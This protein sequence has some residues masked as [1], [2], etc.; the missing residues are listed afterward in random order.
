MKQYIVNVILASVC[1]GV[2]ENVAPRALKPYSKLI[3]MLVVVC[4]II[5]PLMDIIDLI[6]DGLLAEL[7]DKL[8]SIEEEGTEKY[9]EILNEYLYSFSM[10]EFKTKI[11]EILMKEFAIPS[12]ECEITVF[13]ESNSEKITV[14]KMLL[15]LSGRSIFKNPYEIEK[16]FSTLLN[17]ECTVLIK[18]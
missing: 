12:D 4:I 7:R 17:C 14:K 11:N 2:Y 3:C 1:V 6:N 5:S 8:T 9:N 13:T 18:R 10:Q 15:L 16:Y